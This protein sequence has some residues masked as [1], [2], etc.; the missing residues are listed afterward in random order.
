MD[1]DTLTTFVGFVVS[2]LTLLGY[3]MRSHR[4]LNDK[5]DGLNGKLDEFRA[6]ARTDLSAAIEQ[7]RAEAR[8]DNAQTRTE[9]GAA[10]NRLDG[11]MDRLDGRMDRLYEAIL[12]PQPEAVRE[13]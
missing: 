3:L 5:F 10:I 8:A 1:A 6:E 12:R 9:L 13:A 11:R 2:V 4:N 7:A